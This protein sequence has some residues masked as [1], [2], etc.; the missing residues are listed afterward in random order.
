MNCKHSNMNV[1]KVS[2]PRLPDPITEWKRQPSTCPESKNGHQAIR[3]NTHE[4]QAPLDD[5]WCIICMCKPTTHRPPTNTTNTTNTA[6]LDHAYWPAAPERGY[7][8]NRTQAT[9]TNN[10]NTTNT[11]SP[12]HAYWPAA[13]V[14][15]FKGHRTQTTRTNTS[16]HTQTHKHQTQTTI[17]H[18]WATTSTGEHKHVHDTC[19]ESKNCHRAINRCKSQPASLNIQSYY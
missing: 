4:P 12:D 2:T 19:P 9:H 1:S 7:K 15:G 5:K 17:C 11:K 14:R 13:P 16:A 8:G 10:A 18:A 3:Q 6:S